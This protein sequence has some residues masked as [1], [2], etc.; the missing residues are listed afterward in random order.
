M[1]RFEKSCEIAAP[2]STAY[3]QWLHFDKE[4]GWGGE[5]TERVTDQTIAW[6]SDADEGRVRFEPLSGERTRVRV[7]MHCGVADEAVPRRMENTLEA[8]KRFVEAPRKPD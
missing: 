7:A 8:F 1:Q 4:M 2:V 3:S 6:R 5:I